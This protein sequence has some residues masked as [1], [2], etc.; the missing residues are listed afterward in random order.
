MLWS[1]CKKDDEELGVEEQGERCMIYTFTYKGWYLRKALKTWLIRQQLKYSK[2]L[3]SRVG[4]VTTTEHEGFF[5]FPST[6][7][8]F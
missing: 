3:G 1:K 7:I 8:L 6:Q 5:T 2:I 4:E